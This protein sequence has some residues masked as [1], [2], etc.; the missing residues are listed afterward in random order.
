MNAT[1]ATERFDPKGST[2]DTE[3]YDAVASEIQ[4]A[5]TGREWGECRTHRTMAPKAPILHED[6]YHFRPRQRGPTKRCARSALIFELSGRTPTT[7]RKP[8]NPNAGMRSRRS[9]Q[10]RSA[11]R[12]GVKAPTAFG[13]PLF[14]PISLPT[15]TSSLGP[16]P[17]TPAARPALRQVSRGERAAA[18][19]DYQPNTSLLWTTNPTSLSACK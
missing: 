9:F 15:S 10:Y 17:L 19:R 5:R 18:G 16:P 3:W 13:F 12:S 2:E 11:H 8:A 1:V 4:I 6:Y 7:L 14:V